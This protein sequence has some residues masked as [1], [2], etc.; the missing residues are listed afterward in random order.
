[1]ANCR[2]RGDWGND[3]VQLSAVLGFKG[4]DG[5][6]VFGLVGPFLELSVPYGVDIEFGEG[7]VD[8][9]GNV[10]DDWFAGGFECVEDVLKSISVGNSAWRCR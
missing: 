2:G 3:G 6:E 9:V 1:M 4:P 8:E 10:G 5:L 7:G